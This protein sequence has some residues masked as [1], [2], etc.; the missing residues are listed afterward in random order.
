MNPSGSKQLINICHCGFHNRKT[1]Q[2]NLMA[3][4]YWYRKNSL[5]GARSLAF[6]SGP[7]VNTWRLSRTKKKICPP[8][9]CCLLLHTISVLLTAYWKLHRPVHLLVCLHKKVIWSPSRAHNMPHSYWSRRK[10]L[11][12]LPYSNRE[13]QNPRK[14]EET[15][16]Y[17]RAAIKIVK[18][19]Q[20]LKNPPHS[21]ITLQDRSLWKGKSSLADQELSSLLHQAM[22]MAPSDENESSCIFPESSCFRGSPYLDILAR[23]PIY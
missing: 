10:N 3:R 7:S 8:C 9:A 20:D 18:H 23:L 16:L 14:K 6:R 13:V 1:T 2:T 11:W 5:P 12:C 22:K 15:H 19:F 21:L 4:A 17:R